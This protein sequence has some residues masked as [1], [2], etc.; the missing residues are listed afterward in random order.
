M[1]RKQ[2]TPKPANAV[3]PPPPPAPPAK[4]RVPYVT[5]R[6]PYCNGTNHKVTKT[7]QREHT[8]ERW[9]SCNECGYPFRSHQP[10]GKGATQE[11]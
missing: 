8:V 5:L 2:P 6:C 10:R 11:K 4:K 3:K 9:H 1:P 7:S